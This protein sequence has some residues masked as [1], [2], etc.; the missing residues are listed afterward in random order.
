MVAYGV[1]SS[2]VLTLANCLTCFLPLFLI[3]TAGVLKTMKV[4]LQSVLALIKLIILPMLL[5]FNVPLQPDLT[6]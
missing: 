4:A 5:N 6:V 2:A 1:K 3:K